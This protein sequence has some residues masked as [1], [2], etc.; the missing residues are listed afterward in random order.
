MM[1]RLFSLASIIFVIFCIGAILAQFVPFPAMWVSV[2]EFFRG[3]AHMFDTAGAL[4]V[5][6]TPS[7][8]AVYINNQLTGQTPLKKELSKGGYDIKVMLSGYQTYARR[9]TI[10]THD[11]ALVHAKLSKEYGLL[12]IQSTPGGGIV[13]IDGK[14][15]GKLTPFEVKVDPGKYFIK[16]EKDRFYTYEEE[17]VVEQGKSM[18]L[19]ADLVRQ[20]GRVALETNPPGAK[21]YIGDDVIGTTP[22][23]HDKPVGKYVMILKKP[24]FRDKIIE[25]NIAADETLEIKEELTER[26]GAVK[27]TTSPPGAEVYV[28]DAYQGETP[29]RIEKKPGEYHVVIRLKNHREINEDIVIEDN[30][31]KNIQHD[32]DPAIG[33]LR[34]GSEPSHAKV[35]IDSENIGYTPLTINKLPGMYTIRITKPGFKNYVEEIQIKEGAFIQLQPNLERE[36]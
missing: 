14:R 6:S 15:Q 17:I 8:A 32:L 21:A 27:I 12:Q 26:A 25:V 33:E 18:T 16:I 3:L 35:W 9:I 10:S 22:L 30:V 23:V 5:E 28:N 24:D 2:E 36:P 19:T 20:V 11:T 4:A 7:G 31:I 1:K 13:Y 34:I 29:T